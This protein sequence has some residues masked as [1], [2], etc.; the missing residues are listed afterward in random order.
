MKLKNNIILTII[1]L[2]ISSCTFYTFVDGST[3]YENV[4]KIRIKQFQNNAGNG[5]SNI[6]AV[7]TEKTK[8]FFLQNGKFEL[9]DINE[10]VLLIG[11]ITGYSTGI[12]GATSTQTSAESKLTITVSVEFTDYQNEENNIKKSFPRFELYDRNK[13]L[14]SIEDELVSGIADQIVTDIFNSTTMKNEW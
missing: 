3:K 9:V 11:E 10:D 8:D 13:D 12:A 1:T 6:S 14:S 5:P 2:V 4:T 7:F